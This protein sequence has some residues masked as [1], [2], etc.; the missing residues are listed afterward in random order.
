LWKSDVLG[1]NHAAKI[2]SPLARKE[3]PLLGSFGF[4]YDKKKS[5][6]PGAHSQYN[7]IGKN[8][9]FVKINDLG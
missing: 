1:N 6:I 4:L 2:N 7:F 8:P 3:S 9:Y 5:N